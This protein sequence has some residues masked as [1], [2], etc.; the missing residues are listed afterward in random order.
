MFLPEDTRENIYS[1]FQ[2]LE[3]RNSQKVGGGVSAHPRGMCMHRE[4]GNYEPERLLS[5]PRRVMEVPQQSGKEA[6]CETARAGG[7]HHQHVKAGNHQSVMPEVKG[8]GWDWRLGLYPLPSVLAASG[9]SVQSASLPVS[10]VY[11][12][13]LPSGFSEDAREFCLTPT[14]EAAGTWPPANDHETRQSAYIQLFPDM[15]HQAV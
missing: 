13:A 12:C 8:W 4:P 10:A 5:S 11:V 3:T 6:R 7:P 2:W 1:G 9:L 15:A 14:D